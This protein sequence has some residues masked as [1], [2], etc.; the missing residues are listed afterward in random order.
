MTITYGLLE[1]NFLC[2]NRI[3]IVENINTGKQTEAFI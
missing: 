2:L 3:E 1:Q